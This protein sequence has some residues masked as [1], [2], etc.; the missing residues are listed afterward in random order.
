MQVIKKAL[1]RKEETACLRDKEDAKMRMAKK[2]SSF[3]SHY[4]HLTGTAHTVRQNT[5]PID[6]ERCMGPHAV[7]FNMIYL[8]KRFNQDGNIMC[9]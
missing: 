3:D 1:R 2:Q 9:Q 8:Y 5:A 7:Y 4:H 6:C